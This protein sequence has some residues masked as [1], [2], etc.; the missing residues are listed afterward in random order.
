MRMLVAI[1]GGWIALHLIG[2][3]HWLFAGLSLGSVSA[4]ERIARGHRLGR[5]VPPRPCEV[6]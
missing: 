6:A 5:M 3:L 4:W 1:G 2:S